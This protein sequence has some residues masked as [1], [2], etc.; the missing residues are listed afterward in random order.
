MDGHGGTLYLPKNMPHGP[1]QGHTFHGAIQESGNHHLKNS[2]I[3]DPLFQFLFDRLAAE[4]GSCPP[5]AGS[6]RHRQ[7]IWELLKRSSVLKSVGK[8]IRL[9]RWYSIFGHEAY[10]SA[11]L[12]FFLAYL[13]F[14]NQ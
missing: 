8:K 9:G 13:V 12:L 4:L 10:T 6:V 5:D 1:W 3:S 2:D 14:R 11:E 7:E